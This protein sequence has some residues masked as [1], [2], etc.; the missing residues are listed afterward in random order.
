MLGIAQCGIEMPG[1]DSIPQLPFA[2]FMQRDTLACTNTPTTPITHNL[3]THTCTHTHTRTHTHTHTHTHLCSG[4]TRSCRTPRASNEARQQ[5]SSLPSGEQMRV[6]LKTP[7]VGRNA[8]IR[9]VHILQLVC[10][11]SSHI[12]SVPDPCTGRVQYQEDCMYWYV[13]VALSLVGM[14]DIDITCTAKPALG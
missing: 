2:C 4:L 14:N 5:V 10:A 11:M 9:C 12:F 7:D 13:L 3:P 6:G 1:Q 8:I